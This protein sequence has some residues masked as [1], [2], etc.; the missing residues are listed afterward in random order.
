MHNSPIIL[1]HNFTYY[2]MCCMGGRLAECRSCTKYGWQ[3]IV[4]CA[5]CVYQVPCSGGKY[6]AKADKKNVG[7]WDDKVG[8]VGGRKLLTCIVF[9][10]LSIGRSTTTASAGRLRR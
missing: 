1:V 5:R 4:K 6:I 8:W 2:A 9:A 3:V 10:L 7:W